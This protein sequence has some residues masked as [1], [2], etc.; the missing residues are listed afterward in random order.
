MIIIL[1][2]DDCFKQTICENKNKVGIGPYEKI[3]YNLD[4][5][6]Y[7][8]RDPKRVCQPGLASSAAFFPFFTGK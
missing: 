1:N 6:R 2:M 5:G 3:G 7:Y 4:G 8:H